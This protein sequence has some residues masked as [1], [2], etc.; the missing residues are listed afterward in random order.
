MLE[1]YE[2]GTA[3]VFIREKQ[4]DDAK[5]NGFW[6]RFIAAKEIAHLA[7]DE[8]E[9]W[10]NDGAETLD[11]LIK[12][13]EIDRGSPAKEGIQSEV[14]AEIAAIELLYPMEFRQADIDKGTSHSEL[15][16]THEVPQYVIQ[17]A[18][19]PNHMKRARAIWNEIG[20][21][22]LGGVGSNPAGKTK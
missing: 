15:A 11:E 8:K 21:H 2:N 12:E 7:I 1:R 10:S 17:R 20:G 4:D 9:D 16:A 22:E 5:I 18:L 6:L 19:T 3:N 13:H 14:L